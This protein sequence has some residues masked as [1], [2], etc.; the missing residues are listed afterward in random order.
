MKKLIQ[1]AGDVT[2][3]WMIM[4][5]RGYAA[6]DID[7]S[8][9]WGAGFTCK[10]VS[11]AG[12]AALTT[13]LIKEAV[14]SAAPS[15]T[16]I[17][18]RGPAVSEE[19]LKTPMYN[20][21]EKTYISWALFPAKK[22]FKRDYAWRI[23]EF[24]GEDPPSK[25][26]KYK[27]KPSNEFKPNY[28]VI[29]DSN[30]G[31]RESDGEWPN[32][33]ASN[34]M[35]NAI[36]L[37]MTSPI[38]AGRL[39]STLIN[40]HSDALT[41]VL[42]INDLRK[43]SSYVGNAL[44][45]E[46]L[47]G[48]IVKAV[49][50]NGLGRAARVIVCIGASGA[51]IVERKGKTCLVFDPLFQEGD[52]EQ[53][54]PGIVMGYTTCMTAALSQEIACADRSMDWIK[55]AKRGLEAARFLC[56]NGYEKILDDKEKVTG[57]QFPFSGIVEALKKEPV[58]F[59]HAC[60]RFDS[61]AYQTILSSS[62]KDRV[63]EVAMDAAI[64]GPDR[65]FKNI[66]I[67]RVGSWSSVDRIEI[68]SMR[69]ARNII[70]EYIAYYRRGLR[71]ERPL[72]LAVFGP[73]GSGKSFAVKQMAQAL[74]SDRLKTLEF[75]LSQFKSADEL[76]LAFHQ[77]RDFALKQHLP[78]V[79]W[80]EFDAAL[81]GQKLGW[82]RHFLAPMQDGEF[83]KEG[84][85]H[86]IGPAIF[87]FAGSTCSTQQEFEAVKEKDKTT[88][89]NAKKPDFISRLRGYINILGPNPLDKDDKAYMLRRTFLLRSLLSKKAKQL[90][91]TENAELRHL[92]IDNG[93]LNAFIGIDK[94]FHGARSMEAIIDMS[95]LS[96]K[97]KFER[98]CLP[99][100]HQ[101]DLHVDSGRFLKLASSTAII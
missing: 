3:D 90:F 45:W 20:G 97:L 31:F 41:V 62:L 93:V 7:F 53:A 33:I 101:L 63:K 26:I 39:W 70:A 100:P 72:S 12:G 84:V 2:I 71:M 46:Q 59:A 89:K 88:E 82:L 80:D 15:K 54:Y 14:K 50:N 43:N 64:N 51:V 29:D 44:S 91:E 48:E 79:F 57:I 21:M 32:S 60:L 11:Q 28:L 68:E 87:I 24:W 81:E 61:G 83:R 30:L 98:S 67:E 76:P 4:N 38:A 96:G 92:K 94:F 34:L 8:Q 66:P 74:L 13:K 75:N 23:S 47:Y 86:P 35:L 27:S 95:A 16:V 77:I 42:T 55:A 6:E 73:A 40:K 65:A 22:G 58:D 5:P 1:V 56:K 36:I 78:V 52:W 69:S 49:K 85:F 37:K 99:A 19:A 25:G 18:I 9:I 10:A 17:E